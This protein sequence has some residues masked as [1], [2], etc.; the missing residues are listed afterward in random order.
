MRLL[1]RGSVSSLTCCYF[2]YNCPY[3]PNC[4][5]IIPHAA[6]EGIVCLERIIMCHLHNFNKFHTHTQ[7]T[8]HATKT[9]NFISTPIFLIIYI[10]VLHFEYTNEVVYI[11]SWWA[12][13][14]PAVSAVPSGE[15]TASAST[16]K[17]CNNTMSKY[18]ILDTEQYWI[19]LLFG[20]VKSVRIIVEILHIFRRVCGYVY[21]LDI[22]KIFKL[23][24]ISILYNRR[25]AYVLVLFSITDCV[26]V[27]GSCLKYRIVFIFIILLIDY[28]LG[29]CNI[30]KL[31][32]KSLVE[33]ASINCENRHM[34]LDTETATICMGSCE[35]H[36]ALYKI[37]Y[38]GN[39]QLG[40]KFE[41]LK[42]NTPSVFQ[43]LRLS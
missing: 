36:P 41:D 3:V 7:K 20:I 14:S 40:N 38:F 16:P 24:Y 4:T 5:C 15:R 32:K 43:H 29:S 34:L 35:Q 9:S 22:L 26:E 12:W 39:Y 1:L 25:H 37:H 23:E 33:Y 21:Y 18:C 10:H 30:C 6:I 13:C 28:I 42:K 17:Y 27:Y 11:C 19:H 8:F 2:F 31:K